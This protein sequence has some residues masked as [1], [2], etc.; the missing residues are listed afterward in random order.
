[1]KALER[2]QGL[3]NG[4]RNGFSAIYGYTSD[5]DGIRHAMLEEA[6]LDEAD[7]K[8]F[9]VSSAAFINYLKAKRAKNAKST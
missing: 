7:A 1:M 6:A 9:L 3:H 4:L 2:G 5:A 8:F